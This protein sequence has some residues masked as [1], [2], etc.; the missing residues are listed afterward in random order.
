MSYIVIERFADLQDDNRIYEAG[1]TYPH[2][3]LDVSPER[4]A[5]LAGSDNRVGRP[6]I[7]AV[8]GGSDAPTD[9]GKEIP[10]PDEKRAQKS[11]KSRQ[12]GNTDD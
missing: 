5:E 10:A 6:L 11:R 7:E 8:E 3:G 9:D 2:P 1:D 12:R 4:L